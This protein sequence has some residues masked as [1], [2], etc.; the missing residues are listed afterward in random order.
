MFSPLAVVLAFIRRYFM[1]PVHTRVNKPIYFLYRLIS[2]PIHKQSKDYF[3]QEKLPHICI[4]MTKQVRI[5]R[6]DP[7]QK[8]LDLNPIFLIHTKNGITCDLTHVFCGST[9][10]D[11]QLDSNPN[12]YLKLFFLLIK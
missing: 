1:G 11:L 2:D 5:F 7:T 4:N 12:N 3:L 10:P 9:R 8:I 6:P